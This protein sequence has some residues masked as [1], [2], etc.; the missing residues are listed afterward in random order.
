MYEG[1]Q[2]QLCGKEFTSEDS[3][4]V[5]PICG[6]PHHKECYLEHGDCALAQHH[7]EGFTYKASEPS[8]EQV[9]DN[10][11]GTA[12]YCKRCGAKLVEDAEFCLMC[13]QPNSAPVSVIPVAKN[14]GK[15]PLGGLD[16]GEEIAGVKVGELAAT[17]RL[18]SNKYLPK[19]KALNSRRTRLSWN[20]SAAI[21]GEY[22]YFFR[23][24]YLVGFLLIVFGALAVQVANTLLGDPMGQ[25]VSTFG[26][27]FEGGY[28]AALASQDKL[29]ELMQVPGNRALVFRALVPT[30]APIVLNILLAP[31]ANLLYLKTCV[32]RVKTL[33]EFFE[34]FGGKTGT[35][36]H[37]ELLRRGGVN[38]LGIFLAYFSSSIVGY[39]ISWLIGLF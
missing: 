4:V 6:A 33:R 32:K 7:S 1:Q 29:N 5:C 35:S 34:E 3:V 20:W 28:A 11:Q 13:G 37:V 26:S 23:K 30:L 24:M 16:Q 17:V 39:A 31:F 19:F 25:F 9:E 18:N 8:V 38:L 21:F 14:A 12:H 27:F 2:C 15:D 36:Y 10:P 22:Y